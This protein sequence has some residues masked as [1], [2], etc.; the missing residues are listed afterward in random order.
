MNRATCALSCLMAIVLGVSACGG[1]GAPE[2]TSTTGVEATQPPLTFSYAT[3]ESQGLAPKVLEQLTDE[4][5]G[6]VEHGLIV[7]AELVMMSRY[8]INKRRKNHEMSGLQS[9]ITRNASS[10]Y[11]S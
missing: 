8:T 6:Y 10:R 9:P 1:S 7:G 2:P 4:V 5:R 11:S 3:P